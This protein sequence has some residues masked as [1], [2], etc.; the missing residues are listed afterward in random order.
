MLIVPNAWIDEWIFSN[1]W[2]NVAKAQI[3]KW[4][5][6]DDRDNDGRLG[7]L[8]PVGSENGGFSPSEGCVSDN[9]WRNGDCLKRG[10]SLLV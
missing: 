1:D 8:Y 6:S 3:N 5:F 2:V 9:C 10:R 4:I 7:D